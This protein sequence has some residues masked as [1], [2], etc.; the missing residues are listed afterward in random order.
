MFYFTA[1]VDSPADGFSL[2][3]FHPENL[4]FLDIE[5]T[6]LSPENSYIYLI[7]VI[8]IKDGQKKLHQWFLEDFSEEKK[9]IYPTI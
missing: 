2:L 9:L 4:L 8:C 5:T 7:G 1:T 3:S 6:G